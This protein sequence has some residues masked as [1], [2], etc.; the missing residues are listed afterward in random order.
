MD[1][2]TNELTVNADQKILHLIHESKWM[3]QMKLEI[4]DSAKVVLAKESQFKQY[5]MHLEHCLKDYK[6]VKLA[7]IL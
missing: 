2:S 3:L 7:S 4:P 6:E 1:A 5:K